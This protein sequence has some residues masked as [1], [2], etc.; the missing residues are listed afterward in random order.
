MRWSEHAGALSNIQGTP[1]QQ[2][3]VTASDDEHI[4]VLGIIGIRGVAHAPA[5]DALQARLQQ[6]GHHVPG[7]VSR[8][9]R[10][11][12]HRCL[13]SCMQQSGPG[14]SASRFAAWVGEVRRRWQYSACSAEGEGGVHPH[15]AMT[16]GDLLGCA[17]SCVSASSEAHMMQLTAAGLIQAL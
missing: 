6:G 14:S 7:C 10:R 16:G 1:P 3:R 13:T 9:Y 2:G 17:G 12:Q 15:I 11:A 5:Q 4:G 8:R